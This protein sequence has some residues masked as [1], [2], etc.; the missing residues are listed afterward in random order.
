MWTTKNRMPL[1]QNQARQLLFQHILENA[2]DKSIKILR[3]GGW[4]EHVHILIKMHP[5]QALSSIMHLI[6][7][8][9]SSWIRKELENFDLF[10]W[11]DSYWAE[12]ISTSDLRNVKRYI[13][14]QEA[15]HQKVSY[16]D[17]V[18]SRSRS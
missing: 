4:E 13:K 7:G 16:Q 10:D 5:T 18:K 1:L 9:C 12:S 2:E 11:Q 3:I 14:N 6:K 17:E 15:H 8:E